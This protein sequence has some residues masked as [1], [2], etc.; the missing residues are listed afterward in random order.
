MAG[1]TVVS[2]ES[3]PSAEAISRSRFLAFRTASLRPSGLPRASF[4]LPAP[5]DAANELACLDSGVVSSAFM[6]WSCSLDLGDWRLQPG[7]PVVEADSFVWSEDPGWLLDFRGWDEQAM[8]PQE[9]D[10]GDASASWRDSGL[11][12]FKDS[13]EYEHYLMAVPKES[14]GPDDPVTPDPRKNGVSR[15]AWKRSLSQWRSQVL[16]RIEALGIDATAAA[17]AAATM[18]VRVREM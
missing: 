10:T 14:R 2:S 13:W 16:R 17:A 6:Q 3:A 9:A 7:A 12:L 15:N 4:L 11:R 1:P 18:A 5:P 8:L